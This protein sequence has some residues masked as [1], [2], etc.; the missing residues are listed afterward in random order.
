MAEQQRPRG[1]QRNV[2]GTGSGVH[3]TGSG[4]GSGPVGGGG[5]QMGGGSSGRG[6]SSGGFSSSHY[7]G[8]S[9]PSGSSGSGFSGGGYSGGSGGG[10]RGSGGSK[11]PILIIILLVIFLGGGG[12][13]GSL[14]GLFGGGS[15]SSTPTITPQQSQQSQQSQQGGTGLMDLMS[16]FAGSPSA[17]TGWADTNASKP[18]LN[19]E[20]A[21]GSRAK[22][23]KI[24]GNGKDTVTIMVYM[25]GT[26]L[27]S[28]SGMASSDLQEM[29][30]ANLSDKINLIIYTG[31]CAQWKINGISTDVHQIY[32]VFNGGKL[33]RLESNM[34]NTSMTD[35]ANL[36]QFIQYCANNFKAD[37]YELILWD[38]GGGSVSG[39]G[40][41]ELK[42]SSGAMSLA[43]IN[44]ALKAGGVKFDFIGFDACLMA[45]MENALMLNSYGD[46][47][48]ASE[49]TE[50]G[51]GW[52]YTDWLNALSQN[53]SISTLEL[54]KEIVDS[55]VE[56][57]QKKVNGQKATLSVVDLAELA[58]T[59][60]SDFTMFSRSIS[61]L[62]KQNAYKTVSDAR[63]VTREFGAGSGIDQV[64][65]VHL[66]YN[67][68]TEEGNDLAQTLRNAVKYNR[69]SSNMTNAYGLSIYFPYK[70][71]KY[72]DKMAKTYSAIGLDDEYTKCIQDFASVSVSGQAASGG[73]YTSSPVGSL[74]GDLGNLS[75]LGELT[76]LGNVSGG[77]MDSG[78]LIGSL[79]G[80]F[81]GGDLS[82]IAG[83]TDAG[84]FLS[85]RSISDEDLTEYIT[86]NHFDG[87]NLY[88]QGEAGQEY[89]A[90]PESQWALVHDLELNLFYDDGEGY[91]DL[92]RDNVFDFDENGN[93][94]A[95]AGEIWL[96]INDEPVEYYFLDS[97]D[98]GE[99]YFVSGLVPVL[100]NGERADL[101][102]FYDDTAWTIAGA[103]Y[104]YED[105]VDEDG[106][107]VEVETIAK[108]LTAL[109]V[110]TEVLGSVEVE[111]EE[112]Y[113]GNEIAALEEGDVIQPICNYYD[114]DGNFVDAYKLGN[115]ITVSADL[116]IS[117][118]YLGSDGPVK[119]MYVFTDIYGQEYWTAAVDR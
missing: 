43:G 18:S 68:G 4:L 35:P 22:Y 37:R 118:K 25:C 32:Q 42:K 28:R 65:L 90:L 2:T 45:T 38:H 19:T 96:H 84:S 77:S 10:T 106:N 67:L 17:S 95:D 93:L 1:R 40:Y 34:G 86:Q 80:S 83:L 114:Y 57:C 7:S 26:D 56:T 103:V 112:P 63:N 12:G 71:S 27:E 14:L 51:I 100:L 105:A 59:A 91:I 81:L 104:T 88:W 98:D 41:D 16:M 99:N 8:S 78:D 82:S 54:G 119:V 46:Y 39:Y 44:Q 92:G 58:N 62:I 94:L 47:L 116:T 85:G 23:T 102:L 74:F 113:L 21:P 89:L 29:A 13:L 11:L 69:T 31:G 64:D 9:R 33:K 72:V 52:Y 73:S 66:A 60:P 115:P 53:T 5:S 24:K 109:G 108:A 3:K 76:G 79:L 50:P 111:G 36:S 48:I 6:S 15:G 110:E 49:E 87:S 20:V 55:F 75:A 61:G 30:N 70:N 107:K 101:I 117:D 97:V